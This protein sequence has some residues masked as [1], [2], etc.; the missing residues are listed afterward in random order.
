MK[1]CEKTIILTFSGIDY[2]DFPVNVEMFND[3]DKQLT[4]PDQCYYHQSTEPDISNRF[5]DT[6]IKV[7]SDRSSYEVSLKV[8]GPAGELEVFHCL[9]PQAGVVPNDLSFGGQV[10]IHPGV[11]V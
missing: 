6:V 5:L 7:A 3:V 10:D 1:H 2:P 4:T 11:R 9:S 8:I